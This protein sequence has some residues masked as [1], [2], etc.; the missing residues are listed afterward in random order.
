M[1]RDGTN[2]IIVHITESQTTQ[3]ILWQVNTG[4]AIISQ[5]AYRKQ[6]FRADYDIILPGGRV[7]RESEEGRN[8]MGELRRDYPMLLPAYRYV[9]Q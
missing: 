9:L 5:S 6:H 7:V 1:N 4:K 3:H 8:A 2:N